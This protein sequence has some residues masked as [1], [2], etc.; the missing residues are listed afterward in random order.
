MPTVARSVYPMTNVG[1]VA[2]DPV[3]SGAIG[4]RMKASFAQFLSLRH[5]GSGFVFG[6]GSGLPARTSR[7]C[8]PIRTR[9]PRRGSATNPIPADRP[10]HSLSY[11]DINYTLMRPAALP[12]STFTDPQ[13][14]SPT[15]TPRTPTPHLHGRLH[16]R[17]RREEPEP[18][19]G[20]ITQNPPVHY[21]R[22][23]P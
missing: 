14:P 5:G 1:V 16:R 2:N 22:P 8:R 19:R 3:S 21:R 9:T 18:V 20:F 7:C 12:P 13:A 6:Y 17:P 11:P 15:P 10:F 23:R 4:N